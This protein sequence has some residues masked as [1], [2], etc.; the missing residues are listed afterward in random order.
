M[1]AGVLG[2]IEGRSPMPATFLKGEAVR[3]VEAV[4]T[5]EVNQIGGVEKNVARI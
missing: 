1:E 3:I 5:A 4:L 2:L